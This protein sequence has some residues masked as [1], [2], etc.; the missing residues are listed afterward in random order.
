[1]TDKILTELYF[2]KQKGFTGVDRLFKQ[3][4]KKIPLLTRKK[5]REWLHTQPTYSLYKYRNRK[6][7]GRKYW[8][9]GA[10]IMLESDLGFLPSASSNH[11]K[12]G[13][14]IV[15]CLFSRFIITR[16]IK[17][18]EAQHIAKLLQDILSHPQMSVCQSF[19]SDQGGEFKSRF[20]SHILTEKG[21]MQ[22]VTSS[23]STIKCAFAERGIAEIKKRLVKM[24]HFMSETTRGRPK[25][26]WID[27]LEDA[28][29]NYNNSPHSGLGGH[30]PLFASKTENHQFIMDIQNSRMPKKEMT[31][32]LR[33]GTVCRVRSKPSSFGLKV[34]E[35]QASNELFRIAR[36]YSSNYSPFFSQTN[37][38]SEFQRLLSLTSSKTLKGIYLEDLFTNQTS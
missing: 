9:P 18:K 25:A 26:R 17:N 34:S 5:V 20:L 28:T 21:I 38:I 15:I 3:A 32:Y 37:N 23:H 6:P 10:F 8:S 1:M 31:N 14:L 24:R 11:N 19:R 35:P 36:V 22:F 29:A 16:V 30:T 2:A 13:F 7:K 4:K 27:L 12:P 33:S